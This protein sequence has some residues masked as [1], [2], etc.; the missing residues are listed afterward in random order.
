MRSFFLIKKTHRV[1]AAEASRKDV[2]RGRLRKRMLVRYNIVAQL[3]CP[4]LEF[5]FGMKCSTLCGFGCQFCF[6]VLRKPRGSFAEAPRKE[7]MALR[8]RPSP[9]QKKVAKENERK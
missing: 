2:L 7:H 8:K 4:I 6:G 1:Q 5:D 9:R 3:P